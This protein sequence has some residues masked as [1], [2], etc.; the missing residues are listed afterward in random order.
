MSRYYLTCPDPRYF[1]VI[2]WDPPM[3]TFFAQVVDREK[4]RISERDK[5]AAEVQYDYR[6]VTLW[7]GTEK[8]EMQE[9]TN[10][11]SVLTGYVTLSEEMKQTL[12]AEQAASRNQSRLQRDLL[13][14]F[15]KVGFEE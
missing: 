4:L 5:P 11:E 14:R 1:A 2:G 8:G 15:S 3:R 9:V 7:H 12:L 6:N 13:D 10:V